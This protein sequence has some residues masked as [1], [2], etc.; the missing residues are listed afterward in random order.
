MR[1]RI[2]PATVAT[3]T[4]RLVSLSYGEA[5]LDGVYVVS[6][7]F[8]WAA[9]EANRIQFDGDRAALQLERDYYHADI[10]GYWEPLDRSV[11]WGDLEREDRE[12]NELPDFTVELT[13]ERIDSG[14]QVGLAAAGGLDGV[15]FTIELRFPALGRLNLEGSSIPATDAGP[16]FLESSAATYYCD[17]DAITVASG[18]HEHQLSELPEDHDRDD[19]FRVLLTDWSPV[20]RTITITGGPREL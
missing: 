7:Y 6:P 18:F 1:R 8:G 20:E 9:Y 16:V 10:P 19:A 4:D 14:L 5:R 11:E 15:P 2:E 17:Q 3:G 13:V 12:V